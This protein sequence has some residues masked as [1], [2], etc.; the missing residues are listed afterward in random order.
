MRVCARTRVGSRL[1]ADTTGKRGENLCE[2]SEKYLVVFHGGWWRGRAQ[3]PH[4]PPEILCGPWACGAP[5][6]AEAP[7]PGHPGCPW[8]SGSCFWCGWCG[9]ER[10]GG[11][12]G[13]ALLSPPPVSHCTPAAGLWC[14]NWGTTSRLGW[15]HLQEAPS[16]GE[17][18]IQEL[19]GGNVTGPWGQP[20]I[21]HAVLQR[22]GSYRRRCWPLDRAPCRCETPPPLNNQDP[23]L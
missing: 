17:V 10:G 18:W 20:R 12:T 5:A 4:P 15:H 23:A 21:S 16:L 3:A 11:E 6:P 19:T 2:A 8:A 1:L 9:G 7:A 13:P 14:W 22:T